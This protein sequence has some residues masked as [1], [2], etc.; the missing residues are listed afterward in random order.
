MATVLTDRTFLH[1]G[2]DYTDW[3]TVV[4]P[5]YDIDP[6]RDVKVHVRAAGRVTASTTRAQLRTVTLAASD[7]GDDVWD[8]IQ[9]RV[10][11][12]VMVRLPGNPAGETVHGIYQSAP[13]T[14]RDGLRTVTLEVTRLTVPEPG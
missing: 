7:V 10:G 5:V 13:S 3:V 12:L 4:H 11:E 14:V 8:W 6:S 2:N 1:D 9:S